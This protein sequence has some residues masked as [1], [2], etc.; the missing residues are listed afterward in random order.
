MADQRE[1]TLGS[2][3]QDSR[4]YSR[5]VT[6]N[7]SDAWKRMSMKENANNTTNEILN[8]AHH[9]SNPEAELL[10]VSQ[11]PSH[12]SEGSNI[13]HSS[14]VDNIDESKY[15]QQSSLHYSAQQSIHDH[16][17][18]LHI[19]NHELKHADLPEMDGEHID[20]HT[21]QLSNA[22]VLQAHLHHHPN[23]G[24]H[25]GSHVL[26]L[27]H[28]IHPNMLGSSLLV[29]GGSPNSGSPMGLYQHPHV[30]TS[31]LNVPS[32][33]SPRVGSKRQS[34]GLPDEVPFSKRNKTTNR[35]ALEWFYNLVEDPTR[36][37]VSWKG[38]QGHIIINDVNDL[39]KEFKEFRKKENYTLT[40]ILHNFL[41]PY[42][43]Q[44]I[45]GEKKIKNGNV[46]IS[47][48]LECDSPGSELSVFR[49]GNRDKLQKILHRG[50]GLPQR[51]FFKDESNTIIAQ[52][53][54]QIVNL[55]AMQSMTSGLGPQSMIAVPNTVQAILS[56]NLSH[57]DKQELD[58]ILYQAF[59]WWLERRY[60]SATTPGKPKN[61]EKIETKHKKITPQ[62]ENS[63]S[64]IK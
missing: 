12:S 55:L 2:L 13:E 38:I 10:R 8:E 23:M 54:Q 51:R 48:D 28:G 36:N 5:E 6:H 40:N 7:A 61:L 11:H 60:T 44:E 29:P 17:G 41:R 62:H 50:T 1:V 43:F 49:P 27:A 24:M 9:R 58:K 59:N 47:L 16:S 46:Y 52:Q 33:P 63:F 18:S 22:A 34:L 31:L 35:R 21:T 32:S 14:L 15:S 26:A 30:G 4:T 53:Q 37:S 57:E 3:N 64:V 20:P 25:D 39:V 42:N 56:S 45:S 19:S